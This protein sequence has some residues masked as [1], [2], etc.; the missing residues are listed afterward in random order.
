MKE[1]IP[2]PWAPPEHGLVLRFEAEAEWPALA[3]AG[4]FA[5][6]GWTHACAS[7][8]RALVLTPDDGAT[9]ATAE[10]EL[11]VPSTGEWELTVAVANA[12]I[13]AASVQNAKSPARGSLTVG[14][15]VWEW[16]DPKDCASLPAQTLHLTAPKATVRIA[17][18]GGPVGV[19]ALYLRSL[20]SR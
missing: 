5:A 13:P 8:K 4:G 15:H 19:D 6:P 20:G 12:R 17:A 1:P 3:Q 7:E 11:P 14:G 9:P 18:A 2:V 16:D 10:I